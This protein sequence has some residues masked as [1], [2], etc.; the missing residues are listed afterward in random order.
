MRAACKRHLLTGL[1]ALALAALVLTV[2]G[3]AVA[4]ADMAKTHPNHMDG[5]A[6]T[7]IGGAAGGPVPDYRNAPR[8][9]R[10]VLRRKRGLDG[11][12]RP[13]KRFS[14]ACRRGQFRQKLD[15]RYVAVLDK[16]VYGAGVG[17]SGALYDPGRIAQQGLVY[18][19]VGQGTTNCRVYI[20]GAASG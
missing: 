3:S 2:A 19:F 17:G 9:S 20:G 16:S 15:R 8:N 4:R 1:T 11:I 6:G 13:N 10:I 5:G 12:G 14:A 18:V 7:A